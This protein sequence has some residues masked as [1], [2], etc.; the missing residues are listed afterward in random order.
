VLQSVVG[1]ALCACKS[2]PRGDTVPRFHF[3]VRDG[4]THPD[5]V[6]TDLPD[7]TAA[8]VHAVEVSSELLKG[9]AK[10]FWTEGEWTLEVTDDTGLTLFTLHFLAIEAPAT[11]RSQA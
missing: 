11:R 2:F 4:Q 7:V 9:H 3:H 6:G 5:A 8:K 10:S 1:S